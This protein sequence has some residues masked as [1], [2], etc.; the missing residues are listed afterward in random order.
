MTTKT[1]RDL[2]NL[3]NKELVIDETLIVN[4]SLLELFIL[5]L[6]KLQPLGQNNRKR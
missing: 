6:G 2:L 5:S 1:F 3:E 4:A